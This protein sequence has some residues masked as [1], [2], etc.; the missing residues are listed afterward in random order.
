MSKSSV[1]CVIFAAC[2]L[3][4]ASGLRKLSISKIV[5][6]SLSHVD[7]VIQKISRDGENL[8][9]PASN[10]GSDE[11]NYGSD[12]DVGSFT[13]GEVPEIDERGDFYGSD[14]DDTTVK[15][16]EEEEDDVTTDSS[17]GD[18][19]EVGRFDD[20]GSGRGEAAEEVK[21]AVEQAISQTKEVL[22]TAEADNIDLKSDIEKDKGHYCPK[23][24]PLAPK[25]KSGKSAVL[26]AQAPDADCICCTWKCPGDSRVGPDDKFVHKVGNLWP[27]V[28]DDNSHA[29][30]KSSACFSA[31]VVLAAACSILSWSDI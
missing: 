6:G 16:A 13:D 29:S 11:R 23:C 20:Y 4:A 10:Y 1:A 12:A 22:I 25:C 19:G 8:L 30:S 27:E 24:C 5:Q 26:K 9:D 28:E 14:I 2:F 31:V 17:D 3:Q 7:R 21:I 18:D 15:E